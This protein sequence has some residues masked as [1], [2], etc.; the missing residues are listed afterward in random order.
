MHFE[1][2][3]VRSPYSLL[4]GGG[5]INVL[6]GGS[7]HSSVRK[8]ILLKNIFHFYVTYFSQLPIRDR[9]STLTSYSI[10]DREYIL[11]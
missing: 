11:T 10:H 8:G 2:L 5:C 7:H 9:L 4:C 6:L 3:L 1:R